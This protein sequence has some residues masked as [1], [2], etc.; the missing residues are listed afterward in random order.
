MD[1]I[2][3][4]RRLSKYF[5][6]WMNDALSEYIFTKNKTTKTPSQMEDATTRKQRKRRKTLQ[7]VESVMLPLKYEK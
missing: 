3:T 1:K 2:I 7:D 5:E 6:E 4:R